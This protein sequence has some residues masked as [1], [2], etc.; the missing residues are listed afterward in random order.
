MKKTKW[1]HLLMMVSSLWAGLLAADTGFSDVNNQLFDAAHMKNVVDDGILHYAYSKESY[2]EEGRTDTIDVIVENIRNTGRNDQ[3]YEF[4]TGD[5]K[6]PYGARENQ[7]GNGVFVMFL[8]WD[9]HEMERLT[10]G[11][12]RH[13][14]RRIRW[15]LAAGA[16]HKEV[17]IDYDG[18]PI[19]GIQYSIKPYAKDPK[20][21]RYG[22]YANKYY[23][24]TLS[25][26]IPGMIYQVRTIVPDGKNW[27]EG[28]TILTEELLTF[29]GFT[30]TNMPAEVEAT[31]AEI[32]N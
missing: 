30:K 12:W 23:I 4:F 24:F 16:A 6:R 7:L 27:K 29:S 3:S 31:E 32:G 8:E 15:A 26:E 9:V 13:F 19:K 5:H 28:D 20:A 10:K 17:V 11:S 2:I 18:K 22:L 25:D 14:Q 1:I 21:K